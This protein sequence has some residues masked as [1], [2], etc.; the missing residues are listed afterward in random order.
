MQM[1]NPA[2]QN[3]FSYYRRTI[4]RNRLNNQQVRPWR[5]DLAPAVYVAW[6]RFLSLIIQDCSSGS[7]PFLLTTQR[8]LQTILHKPKP[9]LKL[10]AVDYWCFL[11]TQD[12]FC[13]G[14]Q[15]EA[16]NEVNNEMANRMSLFY[17][18]ATPMLKTLSNA[19]TKFVSEVDF[20][21]LPQVR[22]IY[23]N[24]LDQDLVFD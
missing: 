24:V 6:L 7:V 8:D 14:T 17:A 22:S 1:T 5:R 15:L 20:P 9:G 16:E 4:S 11:K 13:V 23:I 3:D 2:I 21:I 12:R 19:T 10:G 18:E